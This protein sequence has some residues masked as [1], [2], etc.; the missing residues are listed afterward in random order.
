MFLSVNIALI[1][2]TQQLLPNNNIS[3][4][5]CIVKGI[6]RMGGKTALHHISLKLKRVK[7]FVTDCL[8]NTPAPEKGGFSFDFKDKLA[9]RQY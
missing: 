3:E 6:I 5:R 9:L 2:L 7:A 4:C 8:R 1:S